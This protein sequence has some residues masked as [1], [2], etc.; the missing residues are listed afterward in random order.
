MRLDLIFSMTAIYINSNLKSLAKF[1]SNSRKIK[2]KDILS[3][4]I[5]Q[6]IT[7]N[8]SISTRIVITYAMKWESCCE[9]V[10]TSVETETTT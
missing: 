9:L 7:K 6:I 8:I 3:R 4:N 10:G 2:F 5:S 1:T